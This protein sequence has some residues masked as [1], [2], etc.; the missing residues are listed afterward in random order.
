M[1]QEV[2]IVVTGRL[3]GRHVCR[4]YN[5]KD[6]LGYIGKVQR[7]VGDAAPYRAKD[8]VAI[9]TRCTGGMNPSPTSGG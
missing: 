1:V 5:A 7:G 4:P 8:A 9:E 6:A 3:C 2:Q